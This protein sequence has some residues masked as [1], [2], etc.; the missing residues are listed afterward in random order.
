VGVV[1]VPDGTAVAE[2]D[3]P[4]LAALRHARSDGVDLVAE[5]GSIPFSGMRVR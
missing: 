3:A 1:G 5:L 2:V 4:R